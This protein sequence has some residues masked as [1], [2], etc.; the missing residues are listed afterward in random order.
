MYVL[1]YDYY[2]FLFSVD[3]V[4]DDVD[5]NNDVLYEVDGFRFIL[6]FWI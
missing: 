1:M 5:G 2:Q 4:D 6:C 3:G